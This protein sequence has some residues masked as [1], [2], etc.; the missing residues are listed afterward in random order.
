MVIARASVN[1]SLLQVTDLG[2]IPLKLLS[3]SL[4][5]TMKLS[6]LLFLALSLTLG[7]CGSSV[8]VS[9][10]RKFYKE[11]CTTCHGSRG[12]GDGPASAALEPKPRDLSDA[13]WQASVT[14]E[15]LRKIIQYG[16]QA[17][18]KEPTMPPNPVL[19]SQADVMESLVAFVR[20]LER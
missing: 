16:G 15:Y 1:A 3:S 8:D 7:S 11:T 17:V 14:D 19:G 9:S 20:S 5:N 10:G 13:T 12:K 2:T 4:P 6:I 18:G